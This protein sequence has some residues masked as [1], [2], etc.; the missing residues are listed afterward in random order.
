M[1]ELSF[2][3]DSL[4]SLVVGVFLLRLVFQVVRTDFRNPLVQAVVRITNPVVMPLRKILPAIGRTDTASVVAV[5]AAQLLK[6]GLLLAMTGSH[7]P[8]LY[9]LS[10]LSV[11]DLADAALML[12]LIAIFGYVILSWVPPG[13]YSPAGRIVSD[14]ATPIMQPLR[15]L[16]PMAGGL[17]LSPVAAILLISVLRMVLNGRIAPFLIGLG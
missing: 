1:R 12:L 4:L 14:I 3:V 6:S 11:V 8:G 7:V 15:R 9:T 16:L 10:V 5:L 2:V 17:D 13:G